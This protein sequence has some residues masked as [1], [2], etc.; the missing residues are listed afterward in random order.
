MRLLILCFFI[1]AIGLC[2]TT[3]NAEQFFV[4]GLSSFEQTKKP[5]PEKVV[6]PWIDKYEFRTET[7]DFDV[8]Q[9]EYT[10]R[11]SP[12]SAK[13][14]NAQKALYN[15]WKNA[16]DFEGQE[17]FCDLKL[18]LHL[19]WLTF[20]ILKEKQSLLD[21]WTVLLKDKQTIYEK[22]MATY[23]FDVEKMVKLRTDKSNLDI[24]RNKQ[25]IEWNYLLQKYN[26]QDV[27]MDFNDFITVETI[28][29]QLTENNPFPKTFEIIDV[30]AEYKKTLLNKEIELELS[31][32]KK[33]ID[34][35]QFRY[36][37]PHSDPLEERLSVGLGVQLFNSGSKKLK[38][39]ELQ[40][41]Q[42]ELRR[43][44]E[45]KM[46]E[47]KANL[48]DLRDELEK[49]ISIFFHLEELMQAERRQLQNLS[50]RIAQKEG[51]SPILLL[52]IEERHLLMKMEA[53]KQKEDL[54]KDYIKYVRQSGKM[55]DTNSANFLTQ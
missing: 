54:L 39:Y 31:E 14:R 28:L 17:I 2:Q 1:P 48:N 52:D 16:P 37:G 43:E 10:I 12:S 55:C 20:Y 19:D 23:A 11:L 45:R 21:D 15:E 26:M 38:L 53:L 3:I 34:F 5:V 9:Q 22:M 4:L 44:T 42:E 33:T 40:I 24:A 51:T 49:D 8:E 36:N 46:Q 35:L 7:R 25:N 29:A 30:E 18:S 50:R 6:F 27:E 32:K 13:V 47:R 41:E